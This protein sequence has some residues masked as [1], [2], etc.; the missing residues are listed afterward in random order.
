MHLTIAKTTDGTPPYALESVPTMVTY[1][2]ALLLRVTK[3]TIYILLCINARTLHNL[4]TINYG[5]V[6]SWVDSVQPVIVEGR[7]SSRG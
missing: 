4:R 6:R 7:A 2:L 1:I 3:L 5:T